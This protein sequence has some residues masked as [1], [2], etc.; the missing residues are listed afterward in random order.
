MVLF[1]SALFITLVYLLPLYWR[2]LA[3]DRA[4]APGDLF[5]PAFFFCMLGLL[6]VPYL[7]LIAADRAYASPELRLSMWVTDLERTAVQYVLL[8]AL[9]LLLMMAGAYSGLAGIVGRALPVL[10]AERFT[11]ARTGRA[12]LV[13]LALGVLMYLYFVSQV[14]GLAFL[15]AHMYLRSALGAGMGYLGMAYMLLLSVAAALLMYRLRWTRNPLRRAAT[16]AGVAFIGALMVSTGGRSQLLTLLVLAFLIAHYA[17]RRRRRLVTPGTAVLGAVLFAIVLIVPLFRHRG[18]Y[19]RYAGRPDVLAQAAFR[20]LTPIAGQFSG[21]DRTAVMLNYFDRADRMWLGRS[22]V[23]LLYAP[24]PRT[25]FPRKPPVDDGVYFKEIA[26]GHPVTP[27]RPAYE[28]QP[29][30]WPMG[31]L[32]PYMNFGLAGLLLGMFLAGVAVGAAY[33]W[34]KRSRYTPFTIYMY[35]Y[36]AMGGFSL[37]VLGIVYFLI[38]TLLALMFFWLFFSPKRWPRPA[39]GAAPAL[40]AGAR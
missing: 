3:R 22:Y 23:D 7:F 37:S 18:A 19:D 6:N 32:V 5:Q 16:Y 34:M 35:S 39:L 14:G 4:R 15:W 27:S 25:F 40:A 9:S 24:I 12:L 29:T 10:R 38:N 30:S 13:A 26:D 33:E 17:V 36:V 1:L 21:F 11:R 20:N 28:M 2:R 31:N 8:S